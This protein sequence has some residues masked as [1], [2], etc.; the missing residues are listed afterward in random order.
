M[1]KIRNTV[2]FLI[3]FFLALTMI[4][5]IIFRFLPVPTSSF[6]VQKRISDIFQDNTQS[7]FYDWTNYENISPSIKLAV[8]AA[9]D[10]K[11][12]EHFGFDF[13]SIEKALSQNEKRKIK[14]GASTITQQTAKNLFL[15]SDK[16]FIRKGLEV[17]FTLLLEIFWSKER[18][19]EVYLN[20]AE[21]G[22]NIYGVKAA[23]KKYFNVNTSKLSFRNA[24]QLAAVLPNP[25]RYKVNSPSPYVQR[26]TIWI[27]RQMNQLGQ[28]ILEKL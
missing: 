17:Y 15:W 5:V 1:K 4:L 14:R 24:A 8:I 3:M 10:Q 11:F 21:F 16:S 27:Q 20:I 18:I 26:R 13:D 23:S 19:L 12:P 9:E 22:E 6:I 25:K 28:E 2:F 7:V